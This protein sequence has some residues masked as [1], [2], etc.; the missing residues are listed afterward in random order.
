MAL[1]NEVLPEKV[2]DYD[3]DFYRSY[4]IDANYDPDIYLRQIDIPLL[5]V[6]GGRDVNVP[7]D[8][9]V[10]YLESLKSDYTGLIDIRVYPQLG[11]SMATWK[12]V[13]HGGY[14]PDYL[15]FVGE[16]AQSHITP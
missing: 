13:F 7:T 11:H 3:A 8:E 16:W 10:A 4:A 1:A 12:G 5:Y 2:R 6:F 15:S 14:P 9:S